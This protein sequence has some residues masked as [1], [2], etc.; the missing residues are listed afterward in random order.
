MSASKFQHNLA[1]LRKHLG[2]SQFDVA[3]LAGCSKA[4]IQSVELCRLELSRPLAAKLQGALGVP[5]DWL[6]LNDLTSP[7]PEPLRVFQNG[8]LPY[9]AKFG[10]TEKLAQAFK[11]LDLLP[12][13]PK[14]FALF[15]HY[16][17]AFW[18]VLIK[19]FGG[20]YKA[21]IGFQAIDYIQKSV[22]TLKAQRPAVLPAKKQRAKP[23]PRLRRS[24]TRHSA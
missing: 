18:D 17:L 14:A 13:D 8:Q 9:Q 1:R 23:E 10:I 22:E 2:L 4:T 15:D 6:L 21:L 3:K 12:N 20:D 16:A 11:I 7:I 19:N 24:R 5:L